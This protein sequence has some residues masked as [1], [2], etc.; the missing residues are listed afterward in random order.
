MVELYDRDKHGR[1]RSFVRVMTFGPHG[2]YPKGTMLVP[3]G[4]FHADEELVFSVVAGEDWRDLDENLGYS[5]FDW[6]SPQELRLISTLLLCEK[7][8]EPPVK[9]YPLAGYAPRILADS[10]DLTSLGTA[11]QVKELLVQL[12]REAKKDI[13]GSAGRFHGALLRCLDKENYLLLSD[14]WDESRLLEVWSKLAPT[15]FVLMRGLHALIKSDMLM[16][17]REFGEE[18]VIM[19]YIALEASFQLI[20]REL[21]RKGA[22]NPTAHDAAVWLHE[23]MYQPYD[24][25][26]PDEFERYFEEFYEGR[27][28]TLHPASRFGDHPISPTMHDDG[29]HLRYALRQVLSYLAVGRHFADFQQAVSEFKERSGRAGGG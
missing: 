21:K 17:H 15:N 2:S 14:Q 29:I 27:V 16:S 25:D 10:I 12:G 8:D 22:Q 3:N 6:I 13:F 28:M 7:I 1:S 9:M 4:I 26:P 18:S 11:P 19:S 24:V 23:V 20:L 5:E